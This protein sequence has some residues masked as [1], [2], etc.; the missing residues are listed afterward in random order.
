MSLV[1]GPLS[2]VRSVDSAETL[3]IDFPLGWTD[4]V[5]RH[6]ILSPDDPSFAFC[7]FRRRSVRSDRAVN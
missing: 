1:V 5:V 3:S 7:S 4:V 2:V 6:P